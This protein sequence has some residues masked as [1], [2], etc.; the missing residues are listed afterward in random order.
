MRKHPR[1]GRTRPHFIWQGVLIVLP[2]FLL[3]ASCLYSLKQ[4]RVVAEHE[5]TSGARK[6]SEFMAQQFLPRALDLNLPWSIDR[7]TSAPE[8][9]PIVLVAKSAAVRAACFVSEDGRSSYPPANGQIPVPA[10]LELGELT[11][12]QQD[13]WITLEESWRKGPASVPLL[14]AFIASRPPERPLHIARYRTAVGL[15]RSGN[16][17]EAVEMMEN[18]SHAPWS[19]LAESGV[20]LAD[21][22]CLQLILWLPEGER[23]EVLDRLS[24]RLIGA[25]SPMADAFWERMPVSSPA[26]ARWLKLKEAHDEGRT[27][28]AAF[29]SNP[30]Q[31]L[32]QF[33]NE[34]FYRLDFAESGKR[35]ILAVSLEELKRAL[36]KIE[37]ELLKPYYLAV[38][39]RLGDHVL[40][41][42]PSGREVLASTANSMGGSPLTIEVFLADPANFHA[43]RR[44]RAIRFAGL[45][46]VS[47]IAV[48][49]GFFSA[50][51]SFHREQVLGEMKTNFV[52]SV[53]HELRAPIA[54]VRLMAEELEQGEAPDAG[55][56]R[57]YHH[58]IAQECRRLSAVIEN[59]LDF[60]RREQGR[61]RFEF[62]PTDLEALLR[63]TAALMR[64]YASEQGVSIEEVYLGTALEVEADGHALQRALVN[65]I[66]NA[67]K[68]SP[69]GSVV[70]L[71][72]EFGN[73]CV[74]LYVEDRGSG[75]AREE[76]ERIFE[77]FY[78]IGSELRRETQGIGLGLSIVKH[79]AE[80]HGGRVLL[81]SEDGAGSRFTIELP[82]RDVASRTLA[83][84]GH[85]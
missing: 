50:W 64:P 39:A 74:F 43:Q 16:T 65:L 5:T 32:L 7:A 34:S 4:D 42:R 30:D 70:T 44:T 47:A 14:E 19:V 51:R 59:V 12:L 21:V 75:I 54:S 27:L 79:I 2:A 23:G 62:E 41:G 48:L 63:E 13:A 8:Q 67:I 84:A 55:K 60:A 26:V 24:P 61:E 57:Q 73:R 80:V 28:Y 36:P 85:E 58:F 20:C 82:L 25:P 46:G 76:R 72:L 31:R 66:D 81:R 83:N 45:I 40:V 77:R 15:K 69:Q 3:A 1:P 68:H 11:P 18:C 17:T 10:P 38:A 33:R 22:A 78:R 49:V 9:D 6:L 37:G 29:S 35:W 53:S 52:S 71:G 56:L